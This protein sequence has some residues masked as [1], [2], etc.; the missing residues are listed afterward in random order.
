[1]LIGWAWAVAMMAAGLSVRSQTL[2]AEQQQKAQA[3]CVFR[4]CFVLSLKLLLLM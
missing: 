3:S 1:M 4:F 2:L